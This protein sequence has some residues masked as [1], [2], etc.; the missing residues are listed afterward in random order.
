MMRL[1]QTCLIIFVTSILILA[2]ASERPPNTLSLLREK[3]AA[4]YQARKQRARELAQQKGFV[5]SARLSD[6]QFIELMAIDPEPLY[7]VT[8]NSISARTISTSFLYSEGGMGLDLSGKNVPL[9]IWDVGGVRLDHQE[10]GG[11]VEQLDNPTKITSHSTE[12][13]GTLVASGVNSNAKGMAFKAFLQALDWNNDTAE[14]ADAADRGVILSN[15]SYGTLAGWVWNYR[16]DNKWAWF[17]NLQ[18]DTF[19]DYHFGY[20]NYYAQDW[21]NIAYLSPHLLIVKAAGNDR[22]DSGPSAGTQYWVWDRSQLDWIIS[23]APRKPDGDFDTLAGSALAKNILTVG[24]V[25]DIISSYSGPEDV[26]MTPY[27]SWG[28]PDDGRVKPDIVANGTSLYSTFESSTNSYHYYSGTSAAAPSVCG[29]LAL[30]QELYHQ[31][32]GRYLL[33]ATLK[34]LAIHTADEAG[35]SMGPDYK[36]GWGLLNTRKAADIIRKDYMQ[37]HLIL[38]QSL[39]QGESFSFRVF[40]E[41]IEPL[42]LTLSWTDPPPLELAPVMLDGK[43]PVLVNDLDIECFRASDNHPI[44]P[45][46]LDVNHPDEPAVRAANHVDNVEQIYWQPDAKGYYHITISHTGPLSNQ[47]QDF[48]LIVSGASQRVFVKPKLYL[49]GPFDPVKHKMTHNLADMSLIPQRSPYDQDPAISPMI[50]ANAVDWVLVELRDTPFGESQSSKSAIL[51]DDGSLWDPEFKDTILR[52]SAMEGSYYL[53]ITHRNH[54]TAISCKPLQFKQDLI[55]DYDFTFTPEKFYGS[56]ATVMP[57]GSCAACAADGDQ[58]QDIWVEDY[59]LLKLN[60]AQNGYHHVDY[61]LNGA[62][63]QDDTILYF[64]NQG[65]ENTRLDMK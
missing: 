35:T 62:V 20:Y 49:Q 25:S 32:H 56:N 48:S 2:R 52:M 64:G 10:F 3:R 21:D 37:G 51:R 58:S 42:I 44:R 33:A 1:Y 53:A 38:E 45:W 54:F 47:K 30:L 41:A 5:S 36:F 17:G 13:A 6:G 28:P 60:F 11:R 9:A 23:T 8:T 14:L 26:Q 19:E 46:V 40:T 15:H 55:T 61:N 63:D 59:Q 4:Q 7:Y 31:Y 39:S 12:V 24:A 65:Q 16:N 57:D 34:G 50:P 18:V 22:K 29:S 43:N 27:S